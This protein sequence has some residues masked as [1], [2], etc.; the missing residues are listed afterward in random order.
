[1][2]TCSDFHVGGYFF[3]CSD[4]TLT[5]TN[6]GSS[7][8]EYC[9]TNGPQLLK[10]TARGT[11]VTFT[12]STSHTYKGFRCTAQ[13][14][15]GTDCRSPSDRASYEVWLETGTSESFTSPNFP[16][17]YSRGDSKRWVFCAVDA[18][19]R[20]QIS[21]R[22]F[23]VGRAFF[24]CSGDVLAISNAESNGQVTRGLCGSIHE[25][26][27][28]TELHRFCGTAGPKFV[29]TNERGTIIRFHASTSGVY[30]GFNCT[31]KAVRHAICLDDNKPTDNEVW[32]NTGSS[33]VFTSPN[34]PFNYGKQDDRDW[35]FCAAQDTDEISISCHDFQV[36]GRY[37]FCL[38]ERIDRREAACDESRVGA[39]AFG[40]VDDTFVVS[41]GD[42]D[43]EFCGSPRAQSVA[44]RG[45]G[46]RVALAVA[47]GGI[48][49]GFNCTAT[50]VRKAICTDASKPAGNEV[51]LET[52][53]SKAF[54]SPNYP[55]N[56]GSNDGR[57]WVFCAVQASDRISITCNDFEVGR[58]FIV[59]FDDFVTISNVG[60]RFSSFCGS[61]GPD[62]VVTTQRGTTVTFSMSSVFSYKG[63]NCT[64]TA[65]SQ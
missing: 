63:F 6:T 8:S 31:A 30:K 62:T 21:C 37:V 24:G 13:A 53:V 54:A 59:C 60:P 1:M 56:Y 35:V 34:Y 9:S 3:G 19:A 12:A 16:S 2:I 48:Y 11:R 42:S 15:R 39:A 47:T 20:I 41:D 49:G 29:K 58:K 45:R 40:C 18:S 7:A 17:S 26:L 27:P 32:L 5:F 52:G 46:L 43:T 28:S 33:E 25:Y 65:V 44:A 10:T 57:E 4:D 36:G 51:W 38:D 22:E 55:L 14:V 23:S 64:A 50:A 61:E